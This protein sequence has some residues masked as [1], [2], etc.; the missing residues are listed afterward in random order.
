MCIEIHLFSLNIKVS[1][2]IIYSLLSKCYDQ[3]EHCSAFESWCRK[4]LEIL[5]DPVI[6]CL[7]SKIWCSDED[8]SIL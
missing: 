7:I 4:T 3:S 1:L 2:K 8:L 5:K 6:F